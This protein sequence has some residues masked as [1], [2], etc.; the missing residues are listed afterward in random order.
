MTRSV[1]LQESL[2]SLRVYRTFGVTQGH[3]FAVH[4]ELVT[5]ESNAVRF[6]WSVQHNG[7]SV[8]VC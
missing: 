5:R 2:L 4:L 6:H 1:L 8:F 3:H 7:S